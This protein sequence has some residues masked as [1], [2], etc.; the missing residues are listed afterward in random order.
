[1]TYE[2]IIDNFKKKIYLPVYLLMGEN[3]YHID[4]LTDFIL[5]NFFE[6]EALKDFNLEILYGKDTTV[7]QIVA[8]AKQYP[9]M[10][11]YRLVIVKEAQSLNKIANLTPYV[12]NPQKQTVLVLCHKYKTIDK[13]TVLY[14]SLEK[15]G[16]L[17]ESPKIY[18]N[19]VAKYVKEM[20]NEKQYLIT[21]STSEIIANHIGADLSRINNELDKFKNIIKEGETITPDLVQE[22]IGISKEYNEFELIN[23]IWS[24]N[25]QKAFEIINYFQSNPKEHPIQKII[26][27]FYT[28]F[29]KLIQYHFSS[30]KSNLRQFN[31]FAEAEKPFL[32]AIKN[33]PYPVVVK[34][35]RLLKIYDLRSKG[36]EGYNISEF[37]LLKELVF[38]I[39]QRKVEI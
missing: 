35:I 23:A 38:R 13:R 24:Q 29:L 14:K 4:K 17:F 9:M 16:G 26:A 2:Q 3:T 12:Q 11:N 36:F 34:I 19:Q 33:Y 18:D 37:E 22:Y 31:I 1:M 39:I 30:N 21:H 6:D 15:T 25:A 27:L 20:A 10:S 7:D 32:N 5:E 28:S 8:L